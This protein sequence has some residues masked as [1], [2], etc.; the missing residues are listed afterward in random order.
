MGPREDRLEWHDYNMLEACVAALRSPD[1]NTQVG[2]YI[3]DPFNKPISKGYNGL[4]RGIN[5]EQIS[6]LR[7]ADSPLDTKYP[8][9]VHAERNAVLNANSDLFG[10]LLYVTMHPCEECAKEIIQSGIKV[11]YYL[12]DPYADLWQTQASKWMLDHAGIKRVKHEW[13]QPALQTNIKILTDRI[14]SQ[15]ST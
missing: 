7:T 12:S 15:T 5:P 4:P 13:H 3:V 10:S 8:Y 1:P 6:W 2:A 11:V 9:I 14:F